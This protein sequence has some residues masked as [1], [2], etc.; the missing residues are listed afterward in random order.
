MVDGLDVVI[1]VVSGEQQ[2][3][4]S[5]ETPVWGLKVKKSKLLNKI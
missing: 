4:Y 5:Q 1:Y 2:Q 3:P